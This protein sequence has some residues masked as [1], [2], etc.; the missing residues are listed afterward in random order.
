MVGIIHRTE[1]ATSYYLCALH[2]HNVHPS[3]LQLTLIFIATSFKGRCVYC[4]TQEYANT[5][6]IFPFT[7][8]KQQ[9]GRHESCTGGKQRM[10]ALSLFTCFKI[11]QHIQRTHYK[12]L[13][14]YRF[15]V[16]EA[17]TCKV[18]KRYL[19]HHYFRASH[20]TNILCTIVQV[21]DCFVKSVTRN[22]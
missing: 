15:V 9:G 5:H 6:T 11:V 13:R 4:D 17:T 12:L 21:N 2:V 7:Y 3:L 16:S 8:S 20:A 18:H 19:T 22:P 14:N 1:Q 10:F